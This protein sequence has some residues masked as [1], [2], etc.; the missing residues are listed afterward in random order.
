LA[1]FSKATAVTLS[2]C[3]PLVDYFAGRKVLSN[4]L[5]LEKIP[6]FV[7]SLVFGIVAI[8]AQ[9]SAM[10]IGMDATD[11]GTGE[12][13]LVACYGLVQ[14]LFK[15]VLPVKLSAYY[16]YP[17]GIGESLPVAFYFYPV[18]VILLLVLVIRYF[19][20]SSLV[21]MGSLFFLVN[22]SLVLQVLPVGS[23]IM[24]DRYVYLPSIGLFLILSFYFIRFMQGTSRYKKPVALSFIA[25]VLMLWVMTFIRIGAWKDSLTLWTDILAKADYNP[26]SAAWYARA[27]LYNDN[28]RY[29][30]AIR[31]IEVYLG[32]HPDDGDSYFKRAYAKLSM[33]DLYGALE[34]LDKSEKLGAKDPSVYNNRGYVKLNLG[35]Y[36]SAMDDFTKAI[37][38]SAGYMDAYKGR[39]D[40]YLI[41]ERYSSAQDDLLKVLEMDPD[42]ADVYNNLGLAK[43]RQGDYQ[44]ALNYLDKANRLRPGFIEAL[45]NR[46]DAKFGLNDYRGAIDDLNRIL[47]QEQVPYAYYYRGKAYLQL[48]M[49]ESACADFERAAG[50]GYVMIDQFVLDSCE[51]FRD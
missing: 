32:T 31:D 14:Y 17:P 20:K 33:D 18:L 38:I 3:L 19:R 36:M 4:R 50:L 46:V 48:G 39:A 47:L 45:Q 44:A 49:G 40:V 1:L 34:D 25:Y 16:E 12:R 22:I 9:K 42:D 43:N 24:A 41:L 7:L 29:A 21:I 11:L 5:M 30:E 27:G 2:L 37:E 23:A 51:A 26:H 8:H 13:L 15:L 10:A 35:D 6:F 28:G